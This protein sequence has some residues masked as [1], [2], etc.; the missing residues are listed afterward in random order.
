MPVQNEVALPPQ[1]LLAAH[2][3]SA[4]SPISVL[5]PPARPVSCSGSSRSVHLPPESRV[6]SAHIGHSI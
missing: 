4:E 5:S 1:V 2:S 6:N 3:V